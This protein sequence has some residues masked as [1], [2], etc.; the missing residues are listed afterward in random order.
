MKMLGQTQKAG[1]GAY[2]E[3]LG[4]CRV[5]LVA[6]VVFMLACNT[7]YLSQHDV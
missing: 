4:E 7:R 3:V 2:L 6:L 1:I 5:L